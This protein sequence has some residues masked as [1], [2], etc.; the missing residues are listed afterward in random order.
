MRHSL[1]SPHLPE[2]DDGVVLAPGHH[3]LGRSERNKPARSPLAAPHSDAYFLPVSPDWLRGG[4]GSRRRICGLCCGDFGGQ[5]A[6]NGQN[7]T[8]EEATS[9]YWVV[10]EGRTDWRKAT[11]APA[12]YSSRSATAGSM[13]MARRAGTHAANTAV[14]T[15]T[16][17]AAAITPGDTPVAPTTSPT[18]S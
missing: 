8:D 5:S 7:E 6:E 1:D 11:G 18:K 16:P 14:N 12:S 13:A 9:H 2:R 10:R 15:S 4:R 17:A 3:D